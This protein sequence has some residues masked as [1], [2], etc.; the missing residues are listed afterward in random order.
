GEPLATTPPIRWTKLV[1][2][3]HMI[4]LCFQQFLRAGATVLFFTWFARFL[5][6]ARQVSQDEAGGLAAWP[7][8][9]GAFGGIV[10]GLISDWLLR[11]TGNSRVAQQGTTFVAMFCATAFGFAAYFTN[12]PSVTVVFMSLSAF[13]ALAGGVNAYSLAIGYGGKQV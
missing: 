5:Q 7:P 4:V 13:C 11:K 3:F 8:L 9:V 10:G 6:E 1:T 12:S 2:D